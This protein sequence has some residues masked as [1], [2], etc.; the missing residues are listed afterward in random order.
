MPGWETAL[1][2]STSVSPLGMVK[3][4]S[5]SKANNGVRKCKSI[6]FGHCNSKDLEG[7]LTQGGLSILQFR[8]LKHMWVKETASGFMANMRQSQK[9]D[10]GTRHPSQ[11]HACA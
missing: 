9:A 8:H 1:S 3:G 6:W 11:C 7:E 5:L 2:E 10:P 4:L